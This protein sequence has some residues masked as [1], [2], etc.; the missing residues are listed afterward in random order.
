MNEQLRNMM[1][2]MESWEAAIEFGIPEEEWAKYDVRRRSDDLYISSLANIFD[3]LRV[4]EADEQQ[5]QMAALAKTLLLFSR[6]SA[7]KYLRGVEISLNQVYSAALYY[8]AGFPATAILLSRS[9]YGLDA[10]N[11]EESFLQ[12][13]LSRRLRTDI[14]FQSLLLE[15]LQSGE[16]SILSRLA[17][18]MHE[19]VTFGL[20]NNP[21]KFIAAKLAFSCVKRFSKT[22]MWDTLRQHAAY[23]TSELWQPFLGNKEAFPL[24]ELFPSQLTAIR[25]GLLGDID[26][27]FTLQMPTS[28][29]KTA[30]C[31]ILIYHEVRARNRKVLFLVP[32]RA[33]AAEIRD[34]MSRRLAD[35]GIRMIAT[36]GGN[37][38]T[39]SETATVEDAE[40]LIVTPEKF[41]AL[42]QVMPGLEDQFGTVICD[43]GQLIDDDTRGLQYE[44]LLTKLRGTDAGPRKV[45]FMS[46][47]LPNVDDIHEWLGG[48][49][50]HLARSKYKPVEVDYA[51]LKPQSRTRKTWQL[52][53][54]P[55][56]ERPRNYFLLRFLTQEDF[57]YLNSATGH[58]RLIG[59]W[60]S[61]LSLTAASALKARRNGPVAV[62]TSTRG[63][64]GIQ[65]LSDALLKLCE[66]NALVAQNAPRL[67]THLADLIEYIGFLFGE[68]FSL[69][70]LL[71]HGAGFHHG[72][73]PQE[74]RRVMEEGIQDG[75]INLLLC[76]NT[77]AE[78][79]NLPIRTLVVH[80]V[81]RY[82]R[83]AQEWKYLP[84]RNIKNIIGRAGRAGKETRGRV[85]FVNENERGRVEEVLREERMMPVHGALYRLIAAINDFAV[86]NKMSLNPSGA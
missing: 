56:Y 77:L 41:T 16:T 73:L 80:T 59:G 39:S 38:P 26:E 36:Y 79:V 33:L 86:R 63:E 28:A 64:K 30:L 44:L 48:Q 21:R 69:T 11:E 14:P 18:T 8:L 82:D 6:G 22:N 75:T 32:F 70:R 65:G 5:R 58:M 85:L 27:T 50:K 29:G 23:Y 61:Y 25:A 74:V 15:M 55:M 53:I 34:G 76:T 12:G 60:R 20:R 62:F 13:F 2:Q 43:E 35:A 83:D 57:R 9:A 67:S 78:G 45:V 52:E 66:T 31:E 4:K 40:V 72:M 17:G 37:I 71:H 10:P 19:Q 3:A 81:R 49:A 46:A 47:T 42:T 68:Q 54:N 51:F 24:W 84:N 1:A 7:A